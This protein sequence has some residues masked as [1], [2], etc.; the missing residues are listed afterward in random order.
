MGS[1]LNETYDKLW[2]TLLFKRSGILTTHEDEL[3]ELVEISLKGM[4]GSEDFFRETDQ[5]DKLACTG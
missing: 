5:S 1:D 4:P 2:L 3:S